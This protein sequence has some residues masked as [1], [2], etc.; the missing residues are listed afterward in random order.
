[1]ELA[2]LGQ[3]ILMD[4]DIDMYGI[5]KHIYARTDEHAQ[6]SPAGGR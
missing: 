2:K 4:N 5:R 1:M 3:K 6:T